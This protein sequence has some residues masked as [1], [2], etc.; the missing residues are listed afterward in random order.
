MIIA[1]DIGNSSINIGYFTPQRLIAQKFPTHPLKTSAEYRKILLDFME[2]KHI[3]K[4]PLACIISSVVLSHTA[5][6]RE[7]LASLSGKETPDILV[8]DSSAASGVILK[9]PDPEGL[10]ADRIANASAAYAMNKAPVAVVD[11][12]TAT[13]I[14]I[15]DGEGSYI[16][17]AIIPGLE[18]MND[19]LDQGT[20]RL[21]RVALKPPDAALGKDTSGC[22]LSGLFFGTAGAVERI[23]EEA[24]KEA[25]IACTIVLTGGYGGLMRGFMRRCHEVDQDLTL[26]GLKI[27]YDKNRPA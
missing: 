10:G 20:S 12:G 9:I 16:G 18:L 2:E 24:E 23:I 3:E 14:T 15:V 27:L 22:I 1:I 4:R 5:V 21:T 8:V 11:F 25:G 6:F 7:T 26:K 13:T 19:A 17:G